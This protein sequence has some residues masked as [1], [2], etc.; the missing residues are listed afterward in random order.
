M[1][2]LDVFG[3]RLLAI[4]REGSWTLFYPGPD[5]KRRP[6]SD[7]LVPDHIGTEA[8]LAEYLAELCHE[9]ASR[10][11]PEVRIRASDQD[12]DV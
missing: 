10:E 3:R 8:E 6:A 12:P 9:W 1:I 4:R 5:G 7:L 11:S 2:E